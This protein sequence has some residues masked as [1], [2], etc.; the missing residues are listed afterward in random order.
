MTTDR[1]CT[2]RRYKNRSTSKISGG[3]AQGK[4]DRQLPTSSSTELTAAD[5]SITGHPCRLDMLPR[6]LYT[7]SHHLHSL[8]S[9]KATRSIRNMSYSL[10]LGGYRNT[11]AHVSFDASSAKIKVISETECPKNASW[12]EPASDGKTFYTLSE[13][14][15]KGAA[16]SLQLKG[17]KVVIGNQRDTPPGPAHSE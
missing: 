3:S 10:L 7:L 16:Y 11:I 17:E 4:V 12:I 15:E 1:A 13:D 6:R 2:E 14:E 9:P 8:T 5:R